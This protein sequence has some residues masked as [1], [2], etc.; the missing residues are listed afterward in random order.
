MGKGKEGR[1]GVSGWGEGEPRTD[2]R[3]DKAVMSD[4]RDEAMAPASDSKARTAEVRS[5]RKAN[6]LSKSSVGR[7]SASRRR[8][9]L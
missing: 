3:T 4:Q 1:D 5:E 8:I 7:R 6:L 9:N 2:R